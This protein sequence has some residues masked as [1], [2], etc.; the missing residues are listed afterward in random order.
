MRVGRSYR[1]RTCDPLVPNQMRYL[2]AL[3]SDFSMLMVSRAGFE[4]AI[5]RV[6]AE[7][8][9]QATLPTD[10]QHYKNMTTKDVHRYFIR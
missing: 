8:V 7:D 10:H 6:Q 9:G 4:P 3:N 1:N 2:A 5:Y